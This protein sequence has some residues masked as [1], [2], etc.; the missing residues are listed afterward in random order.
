MALEPGQSNGSLRIKGGESE[1]TSPTSQSSSPHE[2]SHSTND[3]EKYVEVAQDESWLKAMQDELFMIEKNDMWEL[4]D[5]PF[6]KLVIRVKWEEVYVNQP[7]GFVI[8]GKEDKVYRFHKALYE[9]KRPLEPGM[10][11]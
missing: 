7:E 4:V 9:L 11:K 8:K 10:E 2:S 1:A 3:S 6:E 5:R